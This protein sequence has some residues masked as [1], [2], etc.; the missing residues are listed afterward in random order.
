PS[1]AVRCDTRVNVSP[2]ESVTPVA[3]ACASFHTPTSTTIRCP[4]ARPAGSVTDSLVTF[5]AWA[6]FCCTNVGADAPD[7]VTGADGAEG[8]EVPSAL[9]AVTVKVYAVPLVSA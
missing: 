3:T 6:A 2:A 4:A 5:A 7:G 8:G 9:V 1:P